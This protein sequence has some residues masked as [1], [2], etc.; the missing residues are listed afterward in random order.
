[1]VSPTRELSQQIAY[2]VQQIGEFMDI[3]VHVCV[4]GTSVREDIK[5]LKEGVHVVIG[6]PGRLADMMKKSF[7]KSDYLRIFV[8][9]EAD[10]LLDRGF[11]T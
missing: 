8:L 10:E 3:K 5:I 9:D 4:G 2:V 1:V 11:K 7:L 6:T